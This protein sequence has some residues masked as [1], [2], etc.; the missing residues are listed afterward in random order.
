MTCLHDNDPNEEML[1]NMTRYDQ[2][3]DKEFKCF[4]YK[5]IE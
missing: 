5:K 1:C 2:Q 4:A 3:D